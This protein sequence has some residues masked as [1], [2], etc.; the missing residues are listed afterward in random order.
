MHTSSGLAQVESKA[1][2]QAEVENNDLESREILTRKRVNRRLSLIRT[3]AILFMVASSLSAM[4]GIILMF[5]ISNSGGPI[6]IAAT[7]L[8]AVGI[9]LIS[10]RVARPDASAKRADIATY[11]ILLGLL[12]TVSIAVILL[13]SG[14]SMV[15]AYVLVPAIAS[16]CTLP[17]RDIALSTI[18]SVGLLV[19]LSILERSF[20][21]YRP[22]I[23]ANQNLFLSLFVSVLIV[24]LIGVSLDNFAHRLNDVTTKQEEQTEILGRAYSQI[25]TTQEFG[26]RLSRELNSITSELQAN[27][28]QQASTTQEQASAVTQISSGLQELAETAKQIAQAAKGAATAAG[29]AVVTANTVEETSRLAQTVTSKG[30]EAVSQSTLTIQR[31]RERIEILGQRL[32]NLTEQNRKVSNIIDI[33]DEIADE[34]H[35]LALN[36]SIEA[37]GSTTGGTDGDKSGLNIRR[38]ERFGVIAQEI[39]NLSERSRESTEEV[40]DTIKEMQGAV[41]AAVLVAEEAKKETQATLATSEIA[42]QVIK[43]LNNV[44]LSNANEVK[45]IV[46]VVATVDRGCEEISMATAQQ[47]SATEQ[48]VSSI[49][50]FADVTQ[51]S[52]SSVAQL[53][54]VARRV[55]DQASKLT[56]ILNPASYAG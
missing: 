3:L 11:L 14:S 39:K 53:S 55:D 9:D 52:A 54:Q 31:L 30:L 25:Q 19:T 56:L 36:A 45:Q 21:L 48:I 38:G 47:R 4:L 27:S 50:G 43:Q 8:L 6:G 20:N 51:Q 46:T 24:M 10:Y 42:G 23:D 41:A 33:L 49:R 18:V 26:S 28:G 37:A 12:T 35:L 34:T 2:V 1:A 44:V 40:R 7:S 16:I 5:F 29:S 22:T 32:L 15:F 17:R 13:G